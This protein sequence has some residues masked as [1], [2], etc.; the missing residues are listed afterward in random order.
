[1]QLLKNAHGNLAADTTPVVKKESPQK[2]NYTTKFKDLTDKFDAALDDDFN[3]AQALG[4]VFDMVR[5]TNNFIADKENMTA[6]DKAKI[7]VAATKTFDHFGAV[8]GIFQNDADQFF[9]SDKETELRK[10]GLNV[11]E[12]ES[13]IKKRQA[14]REIKDWA[15]ADAI[16]KELAG[17]HI[18]LKDTANNT[19]WTIE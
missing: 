8:L 15:R 18:V 14:A 19:S 6:S 9:L 13:L 3:T 17:L 7:L 5:L 1:L 10:R 4:H 16:R 2:E 12:I 11:E